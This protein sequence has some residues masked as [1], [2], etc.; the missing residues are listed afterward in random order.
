MNTSLFKSL[1]GSRLGMRKAGFD[2]ALGEDPACAAGLNQ[3]EF[4]AASADAVTNG[5][6]LLLSFRKP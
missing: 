1:E 3:Q 2:S 4:D 5:G 6:N